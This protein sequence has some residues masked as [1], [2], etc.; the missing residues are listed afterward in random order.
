VYERVLA[1][2]KVQPVFDMPVLDTTHLPLSQMVDLWDQALMLNDKIVLL[3]GESESG[4]VI[5]AYMTP[6]EN[7]RTE[8]RAFYAKRRLELQLERDEK[9]RI[10]AQ[11]K[12][13]A[14]LSREEE[15]LRISQLSPRS[16]QAHDE[17]QLKMYYS[18]ISKN[19][20]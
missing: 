20:H 11:Q 7:R 2:Y 19:D 10:A 4:A 14:R 6:T 15:Q 12:E 5:R 8:N 1:R 17:A 3:K 18:T 16:K 13:E 9:A